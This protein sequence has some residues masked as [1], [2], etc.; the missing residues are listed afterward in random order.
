MMRRDRK[1]THSHNAIKST[2][3][4]HLIKSF[5]AIYCYRYFLACSNIISSCSPIC[6]TIFYR[7]LDHCAASGCITRRTAPCLWLFII[8]N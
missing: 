6:T 7:R 8:S 2:L 4:K 1:N 5:Q 3:K